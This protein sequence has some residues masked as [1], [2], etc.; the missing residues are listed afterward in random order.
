MD[1]I[2]NPFCTS[3]STHNTSLNLYKLPCLWNNILIYVFSCTLHCRSIGV[4]LFALSPH[5]S[6]STFRGGALVDTLSWILGCLIVLLVNVFQGST[7]ITTSWTLQ[8]APLSWVFF[9]Q[10][11]VLFLE[12]ET[13]LHHLTTTIFLL[14]HFFKNSTKLQPYLVVSIDFGSPCDS[15]SSPFYHCF[16]DFFNIIDLNPYNNYFVQI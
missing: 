14:L 13:T 12:C 16:L 4:T 2:S 11:N 6:S 1:F 3:S 5:P 7:I 9:T 15:C 8:V 10:Y